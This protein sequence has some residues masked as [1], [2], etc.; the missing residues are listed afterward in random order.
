MADIVQ[1]LGY[2]A[3]AIVQAGAYIHTHCC[4][5]QAYLDMYRI[6][7]G[8]ML[9]EYAELLEKAD[10]YRLTVYATWSV[11]YARLKPLTKQLYNLLAFMHHD[12]IFKDIFRFAVL[13]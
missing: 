7:Q 10:D 8:E 4:T 6:S 3:L 9:E 11:S 5:M 1:E 13:C 2:F 12:Q